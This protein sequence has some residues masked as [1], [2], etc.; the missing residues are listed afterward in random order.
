MDNKCPWNIS[1]NT[2]IFIEENAPILS[3]CQCV[4]SAGQVAMV[5]S[6]ASGTQ[7]WYRHNILFRGCV[8]PIITSLHSFYIDSLVCS[9]LIILIK[10]LSLGTVASKCGT[11]KTHVKYALL[12]VWLI[13]FIINWS[14]DVYFLWWSSKCFSSSSQRH[15]IWSKKLNFIVSSRVHY[16]FC[17]Q[18]SKEIMIPWMH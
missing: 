7:Y 16:M 5:S 13:Y 3:P 18:I 8:P 1:Q 2:A 4:K 15:H 11:C 6:S 17:N 10:S 14:T 12:N 9:Y